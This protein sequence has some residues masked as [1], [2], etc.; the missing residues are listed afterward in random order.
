MTHATYEEWFHQNI[1]NQISG[2]YDWN[3]TGVDL[4]ILDKN[5]NEEVV[6]QQ[7]LDFFSRIGVPHLKEGTIRAMFEAHKYQNTH[8]AIVNMIVLE[9]KEW[10]RVIGENGKKIHAGLKDKLNGI[11]LHTLMG[12]TTFFGRGVGVRKCKKLLAGA[13]IWAVE[14][15]PELDKQRILKIE[16]FEEKTADK[17]LAGIPEFMEF[18]DSIKDF[19]TFETVKDTSNGALVG[20][21]ICMTGFRDKNMSAAIEAAGGEVQSGVSG[22]TTLLVCKDPNSSSG[23][24]KKAKD[25]GI[26]VI[27]IDEMKDML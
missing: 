17:I 9:Q 8:D 10:V 5:D 12:S 23:K 15:L 24:I 18:Y 26:K 16:G 2:E 14:L 19:V 1:K 25:K 4:V 11:D 6:I 22:K 13:G 3:E 21:R 20:Q 7:T 27:S